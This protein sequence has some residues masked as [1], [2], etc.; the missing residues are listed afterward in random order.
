MQ[1]LFLA[2]RPPA[3][4]RLAVPHELPC[5]FA[6]ESAAEFHSPMSN[7]LLQ[8]PD[9][10]A[11]LKFGPSG[12][13]IRR[14]FHLE[15]DL[16]KTDLAHHGKRAG[17]AIT[18]LIWPAARPRSPSDCNQPGCEVGWVETAIKFQGFYV[19]GYES[20]LCPRSPPFVFRLP[21]TKRP[22]AGTRQKNSRSRDRTVD[23]A[24]NSRT[25]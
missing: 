1:V 13:F 6:T 19:K 11:V 16:P 20:P 10:E 12:R 14:Q 5:A 15:L 7:S 4:I 18:W 17:V 23:L 22:H 25:L 24:I 9:D 2:P 8:C 3:L 21:K